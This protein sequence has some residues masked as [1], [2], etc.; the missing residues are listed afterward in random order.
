[1]AARRC[2]SVA[3]RVSAAQRADL[4]FALQQLIGFPD[5]AC[6]A[7]A[8]VALDGATMSLHRF[9]LLTAVAFG[10]VGPTDSALRTDAPI[11]P[12]GTERAEQD[13]ARP[14][15]ATRRAFGVTVPEH[16]SEMER[17]AVGWAVAQFQSAGLELP[18]VEISFSTDSADCNGEQ[19][20]YRLRSQEHSVV[21]CVPG[22]EGAAIDRRRKRTLLHEL[23]HAWDHTTL[24]GTDRRDLQQRFESDD[25]YATD[26]P[27]KERPV[28]RLAETLTWGLLGQ[29]RR[30]L[31]I[32]RACEEVHA[33]FRFVT[34]RS[35]LGTTEPLCEIA[36]EVDRTSESS[37]GFEG[38]FR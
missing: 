35:P 20:V 34:G 29:P 9:T 27:W 19:G 33:D 4:A 8:P 12:T 5:A 11:A 1:M 16:A 31:L 25:W 36:D 3:A 24:T 2:R 10:L 7:V 14:Q 30:P 37:A 6:N 13:A 32:D 18:P 22:L 38:K 15:A 28:E 26:R 21:V 23:A 17:D